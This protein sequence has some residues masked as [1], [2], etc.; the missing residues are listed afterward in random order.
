MLRR[1]RQRTPRSRRPL[2]AGL[3]AVA[4][5]ATALG[6]PLAVRPARDPS[7]PFPCQG[8]ACG[9]TTAEQCWQNCC[10]FSPAEQRAWARRHQVEPP[11]EARCR[12]DEGWDSRP[13]REQEEANSCCTKGKGCAACAARASRAKSCCSA[14]PA[15]ADPGAPRPAGGGWVLGSLS[16]RCRGL[17]TLWVFTGAALPTP[18][19]P[20]AVAEPLAGWLPAVAV[21]VPS[22]RTPPLIPPPRGRS[23]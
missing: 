13:L 1:F 3:T 19:P 6:F 22:W 8:H 17:T 5:L 10:C 16:Q 23:C 18:F 12:A 21:A 11:P 9:C 7:R 20:D 4:Y 15:K 2:A 14:H